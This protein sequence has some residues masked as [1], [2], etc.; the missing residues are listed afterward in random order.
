MKVVVLDH[1]FVLRHVVG[2]YISVTCWIMWQFNWIH[3][4]KHI[5]GYTYVATCDMS[6]AIF[7]IERAHVATYVTSRMA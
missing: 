5:L 4:K 6:V 3:H 2:L 7:Q 1:N